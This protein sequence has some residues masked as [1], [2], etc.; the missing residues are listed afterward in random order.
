MKEQA[1]AKDEARRL[2]RARRRTLTPGERECASRAVCANMLRDS[3]IAESASVA[4]CGGAV[5]V[6]LASPD[7]I[8]LSDFIL[9]LLDRGAAVVSPRWNGETYK[10]AR[11]RSLSG[12]D[13]RR[14]PMNIL[15][16]ARAEI[17]RPSE[18][19]VWTVPGLA[20]TRDG[21]RLGYGGG[22]YDRLLAY[23][24]SDSVKVG[25]AHLFQIVEDLPH[26]PHDVR[27]CRIA[28]PAGIIACL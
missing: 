17:V 12:K 2:M 24:R 4:N 28:T 5:A 3:A 14:G 18:V 9:A 19:A 16:P 10:L 20:F 26:E 25:V 13:L 11:L 6:Y 21:K 27:I 1:E 8:D 22:W 15:E 23:A 7:E